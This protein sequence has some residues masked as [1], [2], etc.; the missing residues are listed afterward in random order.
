ME[1]HITDLQQL[2]GNV[3]ISSS[4]DSVISNDNNNDEQSENDLEDYNTHDETCSP[5]P[6]PV[7]H[8]FR[9]PKPSKVEYECFISGSNFKSNKSSRRIIKR[10]NTGQLQFIYLLLE[11]TTIAHFGRNWR[12]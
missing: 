11:C 8:G 5:Q 2:D 3:S 4:T 12:T 10:D 6:N 7:H 1:T 9:P